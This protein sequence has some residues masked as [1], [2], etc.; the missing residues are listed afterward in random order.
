[1]IL[2]ST[3]VFERGEEAFVG[4]SFPILEFQHVALSGQRDI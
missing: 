3:G 1:M 4:D 2:N